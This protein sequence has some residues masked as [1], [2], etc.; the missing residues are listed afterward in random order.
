MTKR[1]KARVN[2][3]A[4]DGVVKATGAPRPWQS[5]SNNSLKNNGETALTACSCRNCVLP[6]VCLMKAN[7][8]PPLKGNNRVE[9]GRKRGEIRGSSLWQSLSVHSTCATI[10]VVFKFDPGPRYRDQQSTC[11]AN[12][13]KNLTI[14]SHM[15]ALPLHTLTGCLTPAQCIALI[16]QIRP[17][18]ATLYIGDMSVHTLGPRIW[19]GV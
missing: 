3:S 1:W 11:R 14:R 19:G 10:A 13:G 8:L 4:P 17:H 7:L 9:L 18:H 16:E 15:N 2:G 5:G 6:C 12:F